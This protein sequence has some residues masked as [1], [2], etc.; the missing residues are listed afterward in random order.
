MAYEEN[1]S[2][3]IEK[4]LKHAAKKA[5]KCEPVLAK[6]IKKKGSTDLFCTR[7]CKPIQEST[8]CIVDVTYKNTNVGLEYATAQG[9]NKPVIVTKYIPDTTN[10]L[11][12]K[13]LAILRK[14]K[15]KDK[16]QFAVLPLGIPSDISGKTY[17]EYPNELELLR[18]I[19]EAIDV[20]SN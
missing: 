3:L 13:E 18:K 5:L 8:Y 11:E 1:R 4:I 17:I 10:K 14:L 7:V 9:F 15:E 6:N 16:I 2:K 20:R 12:K 19:R